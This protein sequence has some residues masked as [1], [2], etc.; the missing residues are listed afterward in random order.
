MVR[1][2]RTLSKVRERLIRYS[3][4]AKN[5]LHAALDGYLPELHR[6]FWSMNSRTL[7]AILDRCP[8]P[9]DVISMKLSDLREMIARSVRKKEDRASS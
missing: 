9:E 6:I 8:L 3:V 5:A 1:Q 2:L 7:W 4:G